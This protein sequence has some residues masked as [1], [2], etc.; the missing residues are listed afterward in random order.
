M[1][2]FPFFAVAAAVLAASA[3]LADIQ[4]LSVGDSRCVGMLGMD[5]NACFPGSGTLHAEA[6]LDS[7]LSAA[8]YD[9][10]LIWAG[11][12]DCGVYSR[13]NPTTTVRTLKRMGAAV[14]AQGGTPVWV[15]DAPLFV[16]RQHVVDFSNEV[17]DRQLGFGPNLGVVLDSGALAEPEGWFHHAPD[18]VHPGPE[19]Q[20]RIFDAAMEATQ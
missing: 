8:S 12:N 10:V 1:M 15:T 14:R 19:L 9:V 4:V 20:Q 2:R 11:T 3:A 17:R 5:T 13:C 18:G 6:R 16:F 7:E